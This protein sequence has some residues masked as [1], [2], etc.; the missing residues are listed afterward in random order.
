MGAAAD[1]RF[2]LIFAR[3]YQA[4][5]VVI[6]VAMGVYQ[7]ALL[8]C[9]GGPSHC[10]GLINVGATWALIAAGVAAFCT[11]WTRYKDRRPMLI[12]SV[13]GLAA[14][15]VMCA[16]DMLRGYPPTSSVVLI[17]GALLPY[18]VTTT[19]ERRNAAKAAAVGL[20]LMVCGCQV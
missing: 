11:R 18:S 15:A 13:V 7:V 1:A 16:C 2:R 9:N 5:L 20:L 6:T 12:Y 19:A 14:V 8:V 3:R 17:P 4:A 10:H